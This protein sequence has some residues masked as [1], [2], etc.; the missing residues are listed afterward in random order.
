MCNIL[1]FFKRTLSFLQFYCVILSTKKIGVLIFLAIFELLCFAMKI[2]ASRCFALLICV[3][4][5]EYV[6]IWFCFSKIFFS[7]K[8]QNFFVFF[9]LNRSFFNLKLEILSFLSSFF[10]LLCFAY[11][12]CLPFI[13]N[14]IFFKIIVLFFFALIDTVFSC[15][16]QKHWHF[17][18]QV[19][20]IIPLLQ[21][22]VKFSVFPLFLRAII[23][24]LV[25]EKNVIRYVRNK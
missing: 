7:L 17:L 25:L 14:E 21:F 3:L 4:V 11:S 23:E 24:F 6:F 15:F 1:Y 10:T 8:K 9:T 2:F 13:E 16:I 22:G 19:C 20:T 12:V 5:L 18:F